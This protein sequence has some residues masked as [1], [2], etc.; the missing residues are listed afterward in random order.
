MLVLLVVLTLTVDT[1]TSH[2]AIAYTYRSRPSCEEAKNLTLSCLNGEITQLHSAAASIYG[3]LNRLCDPLVS[4][5]TCY[6]CRYVV[7]CL[8]H[9][10]LTRLLLNSGRSGKF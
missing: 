1:L 2:T 6:L 9:A 8:C 5:Q 4:E 10:L 7:K 3:N